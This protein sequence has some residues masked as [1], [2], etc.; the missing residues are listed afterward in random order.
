MHKPF[1]RNNKANKIAE[2]SRLSFGAQQHNR[3]YYPLGL[4]CKSTLPSNPTCGKKNNRKF[5]SV[6]YEMLT[7]LTCVKHIKTVQWVK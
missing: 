2:C 4:L 7:P 1:R 5:N 3:D 6:D